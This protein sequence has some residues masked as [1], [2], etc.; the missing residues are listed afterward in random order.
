MIKYLRTPHLPF[1]EGMTKDDRVWKDT[2]YFDQTEVVVTEKMDGENTTIYRNACHARSLSSIHRKD[3]AWL[4]NYMQNFQ[5]N[6][7]ENWRVCG[8][9]LFAKHSIFY[10][11]LES[12]FLVFSVWNERNICLS[13]EETEQFCKQ[14]HLPMVP[15][16]YQGIYD[17][18]LIQTLAKTVVQHGGEGLV[19][20]KRDSFSYHDFD[21]SIAKFVRRDHVQT[22]KHWT[23]M[24]LTQN[25][26][27][28]EEKNGNV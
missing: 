20:R 16:L 11:N 7:P 21:Q 9:Y 12:Y 19:V 3:H 4:L 14:L 23:A 22:T 5:Y 13:W 28:K 2:H 15:V 24:N 10:S 17:E 6:I 25:Q 18:S 26:L 27:R 8:E 1:S